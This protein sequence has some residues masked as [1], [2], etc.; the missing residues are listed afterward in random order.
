MQKVSFPPIRSGIQVTHV[1]REPP[2]RSWSRYKKV[3]IDNPRDSNLL[4]RQKLWNFQ[5]LNRG[6]FRSQLNSLP[7]IPYRVKPNLV[8]KVSVGCQA[9]LTTRLN[10]GV[11]VIFPSINE[12]K[13]KIINGLSDDE[14]NKENADDRRH[15]ACSPMHEDDN[16]SDDFDDV[17]DDYEELDYESVV[18]KQNAST[19]T[20]NRR[21]VYSKQTRRRK[22]T[23][24][25]RNAISKRSILKTYKTP[26]IQSGKKNVKFDK[27]TTD[28]EFENE[29]FDQDADAEKLKLDNSASTGLE[30]EEGEMP[31][32]QKV[33]IK[34][35]EREHPVLSRESS[36]SIHS[37]KSNDSVGSELKLSLENIGHSS[38]LS[39]ENLSILDY[40]SGSR[41]DRSFR[42]DSRKASTSRNQESRRQFVDQDA[43]REWFQKLVGDREIVDMK[44]YNSFAR[45]KPCVNESGQSD[46]NDATKQTPRKNMTPRVNDEFPGYRQ[47]VSKANQKGANNQQPANK[48]KSSRRSMISIGKFY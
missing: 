8:E 13:T 22:K 45:I 43:D 4:Q 7:D 6:A 48:N 17:S 47:V 24:R 12:L 10:A 15:K 2:E 44:T 36:A 25:E 19:M 21:S 14:N 9:D 29:T 40:I 33:E 23:V 28:D 34:N 38:H 46:S 35:I 41:T 31:M 32:I 1:P 39:L 16:Y 11:R 30:V 37:V 5:K 3:L 20:D 18:R 27:V 42:G 26:R